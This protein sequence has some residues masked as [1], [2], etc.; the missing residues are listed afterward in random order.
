M[1]MSPIVHLQPAR[2]S[3]SHGVASCV[4]DDDG[5]L[6]AHFVGFCSSLGAVL[7]YDGIPVLKIPSDRFRPLAICAA[8]RDSNRVSHAVL[9]ACWPS[10]NR[11]DRTSMEQPP[12]RK[13][14]RAEQREHLCFVVWTPGEPNEV[15]SIDNVGEEEFRDIAVL[16]EGSD[17]LSVLIFCVRGFVARYRISLR[18]ENS[19][20]ISLCNLSDDMRDVISQNE[21]ASSAMFMRRGSYVIA[22]TA[23][24]KS[25]LVQAVPYPL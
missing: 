24:E 10:K 1:A 9:L 15:L 17:A 12:S 13:R 18:A 23:P 21:V 16:E 6:I 5:D 25:T 4:Q 22:V 19:F 2:P 20:Q 7:M 14:H 11:F 8:R 3:K